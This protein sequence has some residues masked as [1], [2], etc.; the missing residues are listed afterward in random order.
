MATIA[1]GA[2]V[3]AEI[4]VLGGPLGVA[5]GAVIG[6]LVG[7]GVGLLLAK[8]V[9][10]AN[11][12]AGTSLGEGTQTKACAD[13]GDG[14]DCFE[15][16]DGADPEEFAKQLKEQQDAIN[17]LSPDELLKRLADGDARKAATG[18]YRGAGDAA[19]RA[20]A[21]DAAGRSAAD[22][23]R[24]QALASGKSLGEANA[25]AEQA[26][27]GALAGKDATHALDWVAGG[28]GAISGVG[29]RSINRSIG[30]QWKSTKSGSQLSRREQLRKA[31]EKAKSQ[32]KSKMDVDMENC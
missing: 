26:A 23:A 30:S 15:P 18:S 8:A 25:I 31:A 17:E 5:A 4:G 3:G 7:L 22:A 2:E 10:N 1:A 21:R 32:G 28:D 6:G 12:D 11:S 29:D 20:A 9:E 16:P 14:P 27:K 13:C 24:K 19:A